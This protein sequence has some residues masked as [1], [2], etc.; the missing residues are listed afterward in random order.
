MCLKTFFGKAYLWEANSRLVFGRVTPKYQIMRSY[1]S[2][3]PSMPP[4]HPTQPE[5]KPPQRLFVL[6]RP[7]FGGFGLKNHQFERDFSGPCL[8]HWTTINNDWWVFF[9]LFRKAPREGRPLPVLGRGGDKEYMGKCA[10]HVVGKLVFLGKKHHQK[11]WRFVKYGK[12]RHLCKHF[13]LSCFLNRLPLTFT[14]VYFRGSRKS[15]E[16]ERVFLCGSDPW[17]KRVK[18]ETWS[19]GWVGPLPSSSGK[20]MF[21]MIPN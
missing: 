20:S 6:A 9:S 7:F 19:H 17:T 15:W 10:K 4:P 12:K 13:F 14:F 1:K 2:P 18:I 21:I 3:T 5:I 16:G 11:R 8:N